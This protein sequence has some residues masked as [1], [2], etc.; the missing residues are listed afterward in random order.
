MRSFFAATLMTASI[1]VVAQF[2]ATD[3][4]YLPGDILVML[5]PHGRAAS[6]ATDLE[7]LDGVPTGIEVVEEVSAPMRTWLLHFDARAIAQEKMLSAVQRHPS[8]MIAQNNHQAYERVVPN[9]PNFSSQW[10]HVEAGDHDI[11]TDLAWNTTTGGTTAM[12]DA[13]VVCQVEGGNLAHT[14]LAANAWT[15]AGEI[16]NNGVDDDGNGYVDDKQ[17]WDPSSGTDNNIFSSSH[18]TQCAGMIGARGNNNLGV[19]GANWNVKIMPVTVGSLTEANVIASYTY[20]LVMRRRYNSSNGAQGAFVVATNSSWGIDNANPNNYPLWCNFYDTLG[21]AGI[22]SCGATANNSVNVDVVGDMP[23]AC[24][25][26]YLISVTATNNADQRTFS[27]YGHTTIDV[28]APGSS[29]WTTSGSSSYGAASG[30]SFAS[31]LTAG[32]IALLYSAPC[33]GLIQLAKS[34]PAAGALAVRAALFAGV[35]QVGNLPGN[36]VTGGRINANNSLQY[37]ITNCATYAPGVQL[38][39]KVRLE[40]PYLSGTGLMNDDLRSGGL[41][42]LSEP[43]SALGFSNVAG[44][45][46]EA[47]TAA[48]LATTGNNAIVDWVRI[49]LRSAG[50]PSTIVATKQCLVQRDG[51]VVNAD[52]SSPITFGVGAASYYVAVRHRNHLGCM[53]GTALGLVSSAVAVDFTSAA[54]STYG[55]EAR[56]TVGSTNVLWMGNVVRDGNLRYT[57]SLNDRDPI[58]VRV[59]STTPNNTVAGYYVEDCTLNGS[60]R[61]TGSGNDRDPILVNV[62]ST[63]PNNVRIEQL[64]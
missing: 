15:N 28:G 20:P 18:G 23:T 25:S 45:G 27:G 56:K 58:L 12:G 48:V 2:T 49:E 21:T 33:T 53:T 46:G 1:T 62:G 16:D 37:I 42:P 54:T 32:V 30:T 5:A 51:D 22:L 7:H 43:Y 40:G 29:V 50:A 8:V 60:V 44:G 63:T 11:D 61:Y 26:P 64:P 14:D 24:S 6:I 17:G 52:G 47:T 9:D 34:D 4:G 59:G 55:T 3:S 19:A 41:L 31:P 13:I 39:V 10:H 35:E 36:T 57:G 38:S